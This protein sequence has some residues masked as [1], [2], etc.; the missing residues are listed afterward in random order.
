TLGADEALNSRTQDVAAEVRARTEGRGADLAFEVVG[1]SPTLKIALDSVRKGGQVTLVGNL[2]ANVEFPLQW[3]VTRE[4]TLNGCCSSQ[5]EYNACLDMI[6]RGR[7]DVKA[8]LS[9]TAPLADGAS[10]FKRLYA[11][12]PGLLK[13]MLQPP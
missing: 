2:A 4:I 10:W 7:I 3:V 1:I 5:G 6:A 9:A 11:A 8:L 12:E 13:V